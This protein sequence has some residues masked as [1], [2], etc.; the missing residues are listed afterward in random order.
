MSGPSFEDILESFKKSTDTT[1]I[2][3]LLSEEDAQKLV[4]A[5]PKVV[6]TWIRVKGPA[7]E[8]QNE[9]WQWLWNHVTW[10]EAE[11]RDIS[12]LPEIKFKRVF[13]IVKGNRLI[14]PDGTVSGFAD[15]YLK[16]II[17]SRIKGGQR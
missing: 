5:W 1:N 7:P 16:Q 2:I 10:P 8:S 13:N 4:V 9:R 3:P 12:G 11:L 14:F 17:I 15:K 6:L